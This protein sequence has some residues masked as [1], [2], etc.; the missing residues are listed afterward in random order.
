MGFRSWLLRRTRM[1]FSPTP[2]SLID[3]VEK[4]KNLVLRFLH[5]PFL[6]K[7]FKQLKICA[8]REVEDLP[9]LKLKHLTTPPCKLQNLLLTPF[10]IFWQTTECDSIMEPHVSSYFGIRG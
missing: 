9:T 1:D 6:S 10:A 5:T 7:T 4:L 8:A 3:S 2:F